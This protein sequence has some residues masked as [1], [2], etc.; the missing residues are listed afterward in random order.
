MLIS[1]NTVIDGQTSND[2]SIILTF[3]SSVA[4]SNF[5]KEDINVTNGAISDFA[6][7]G[8]NYTATFSA[9]TPGATIIKVDANK[10][11]DA[12]GNNN[13]ASNE[14]NW[15]FNNTQ[16]GNTVVEQQ[17]NPQTYNIDVTNSGHA[18]ILTGGPVSNNNVNLNE[19]DTV[20]FVV[21]V[22]SIHPFY[23]KKSSDDTIVPLISGTQGTTNTTLT[24]Q[25]T[26]PGEYYY[27]CG[28]H[29]FMRGT[30]NVT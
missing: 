28:A 24:W 19:N 15:T 12:I 1:S 10:Y 26:P 20:N 21:N 14:F 17:P 8:R 13:L 7:S 27:I 9:S 22:E 18:Y 6:G 4:T 16:G 5:V 11:S 2:S 3:T 25:A 30:I 29:E 23:I